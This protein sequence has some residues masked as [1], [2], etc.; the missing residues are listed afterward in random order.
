MVGY[1]SRGSGIKIH[2]KGREKSGS[3][4]TNRQDVIH[5]GL[6]GSGGQPALWLGYFVQD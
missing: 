5:P 1:K 4:S 2:K 6:S 3:V